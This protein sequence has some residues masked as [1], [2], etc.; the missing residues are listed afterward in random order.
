MFIRVIER[1]KVS[2]LLHL[3]WRMCDN[4]EEHWKRIMTIKM[5]WIT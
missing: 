1:V 4:I 3:G 2:T 5:T